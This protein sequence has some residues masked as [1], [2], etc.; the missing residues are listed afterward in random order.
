[1]NFMKNISMRQKLIFVVVCYLVLFAVNATLSLGSLKKS[2]DGGHQM[3]ENYMTNIINLTA[4]SN[5]MSQLYLWQKRHIISPDDSAMNLAE[6]HM[7]QAKSELDK[8]LNAFENTL[9]PGEETELFNQ[10]NIDLKTLLNLNTKIV[11]LSSTNDV[12]AESISNGQFYTQFDDLG[13]S[14]QKMLDTNIE[15]AKLL[16]ESNDQEYDSALNMVWLLSFFAVALTTLIVISIEK[17]VINRL[18]SLQKSIESIESSH[19][20]DATNHID[21]G[22]EIAQV[23]SAY[24]KMLSGFRELVEEVKQTVGT[25]QGSSE[26]LTELASLSSNNATNSSD[27][28]T[29]IATASQEMSTTVAEIARNANDASSA[30]QQAERQAKDG[31]DVVAD[32]ITTINTLSQT[33]S[34]AS[35]ATQEVKSQTQAIGSV[36]EVING[37]ADQTNLLALNAA[38]EAAR[39]G[40]QGRGFAVVADEVR[41]LAQR[42][43]ES[44]QEIKN[45]IVKL[46]SETGNA[47]S[48]IESSMNDVE[49]CVEQ[50]EKAGGSLREITESVSQI[51]EMNLLIATATDEQQSVSQEIGQQASEAN[52]IADDAA[53]KASSVANTSSEL[54]GIAKHMETLVKDYQV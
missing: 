19:K 35:D 38:I 54:A 17:M 28:L 33:M 21:G 34:N 45:T 40:E 32:T 23:A 50:A 5:E 52:N 49:K 39:A 37:I 36:L 44:T 43:S 2:N 47:V 4:A 3:Y 18:V 42:T 51:T 26:G 11:G 16:D 1:M 10:F 6:T 53:E 27:R 13:T 46:Q 48:L 30:V 25:L 12:K 7:N 24:F 15:G 20:L 41:T 29:A 22:D 31:D 9:D 14:L 8:Y